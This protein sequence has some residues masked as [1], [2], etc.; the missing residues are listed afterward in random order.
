M[1]VSCVLLCMVFHQAQL[2]LQGQRHEADN[3]LRNPARVDTSLAREEDE[4]PSPSQ[5]L[6]AKEPVVHYNGRTLAQT[7]ATARE[8]SEGYRSLVSFNDAVEYFT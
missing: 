4:T 3:S 6:S 8:P 2:L 7:A 5:R 1:G